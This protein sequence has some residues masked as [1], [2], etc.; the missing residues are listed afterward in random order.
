MAEYFFDCRE[1]ESNCLGILMFSLFHQGKEEL[2]QKILDHVN[3][4]TEWVHNKVQRHRSSDAYWH[5]VCHG[6]QSRNNILNFSSLFLFGFTF[7]FMNA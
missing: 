2:C 5:Q 7:N 3:E 6:I 4:N 1:L